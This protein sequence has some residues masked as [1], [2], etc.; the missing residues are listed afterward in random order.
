MKF[1]D[2]VLQDW[3][4][5]KAR[6]FIPRGA[7]VLDIGCADGKLFKRLQGEVADDSLGIE[8][9][10][11]HSGTA[12]SVRLIA[13]RFPDD[14]PPVEAFDVI[15]L[16]A[17]L[18]H[19]PPSRYANLKEDCLRFLKPG[20]FLIITVPSSRVDSI[21]SVLRRCHLLDGMSL[22]EHHGYAVQK[23]KDIFSS[24]QFILVKHRCFQLGLNNL[25]VFTRTHAA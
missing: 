4:I 19:F 12:G 24:P 23:T 13:G 3:R 14:M 2:R 20:G 15:T 7:R 11:S 25:F 10:L 9:T 5:V 1:L 22:D 6:P 18:E 21:L 17:V 8:P 16:L